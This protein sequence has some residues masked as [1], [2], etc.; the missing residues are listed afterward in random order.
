MWVGRK[1]ERYGNSLR[2]SKRVGVNMVNILHLL[3]KTGVEGISQDVI[4]L[5]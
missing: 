5:V 2:K 4:F 3:R 1:D